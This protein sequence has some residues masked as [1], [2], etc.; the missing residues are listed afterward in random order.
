[1]AAKVIAAIGTAL[2]VATVAYQVYDNAAYTGLLPM[3]WVHCEETDLT[4]R[5]ATTTTAR[6][7]ATIDLTNTGSRRVTVYNVAYVDPHNNTYASLAQAVF[8]T[9]L[10][11]KIDHDLHQRKQSPNRSQAMAVMDP[12]DELVIDA[13]TPKE[14]D[15]K[16]LYTV[17][18]A[19]RSCNLKMRITYQT[20]PTTSTKLSSWWP[21]ARVQTTDYKI[22]MP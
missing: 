3:A 6:K 10:Y 12:Y 22:S 11:D 18:N 19:I 17:H 20:S 21:S 7:T 1:M 9:N 5:G 16:W 4:K 15:D 2:S 14:P 13:V 8:A